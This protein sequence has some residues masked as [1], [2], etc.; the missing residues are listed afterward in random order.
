MRHVTVWRISSVPMVI[1]ITDVAREIINQ[2]NQFKSSKHPSEHELI[3]HAINIQIRLLCLFNTLKTTKTYS[4]F[5]SQ[6]SESFFIFRNSNGIST[7][8]VYRIHININVYP[9]II[10]IQERTYGNNTNKK[11]IDITNA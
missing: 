6:N 2:I 5:F 9:N 11:R 8:Y 3:N 4:F 10:H 7:G 1:C